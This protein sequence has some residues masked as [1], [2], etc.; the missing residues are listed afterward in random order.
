MARAEKIATVVTPLVAMATLAIGLQIGARSAVRAAI[1]YGAPRAKDS[2]VYA[3]QLVSV[4][5]D[6]GV[7][8]AVPARGITVKAHAKGG[9]AIW[10]GDTNADGVAEIT[11]DM[12]WAKPG[13]AVDL[14]IT[15]AGLD[16]PLGRGAITWSDA[17]EGA[18]ANANDD[19]PAAAFARPSR[20]EGDV[21]LDLA[22][23][24][25]ALTP[26]F[27][28][29]AWIH[30][31]DKA[32][33]ASLAGVSIDAEPE[34]GLS[35]G[36]TKATTCDGGWAEI[37]AEPLIHV[38]GLSLHARARDGRTGDWAGA[39]P[40]A[41]GASHVALPSSIDADSPLSLE[42]VAPSAR[43]IVYLEVDDEAG[44]AYATALALETTP[45]SM[46]RAQFTLPAMHEGLHWLVTSG[47]PRGAESLR[48][49]AIARP[50]WVDA[51]GSRKMD[52]RCTLGPFLATHP[53]SAFPRWIALD[54]FAGRKDANALNQK[55]GLFLA[56]GSIVVAA[57]LEL[58]LILRAVARTRADLARVA[59]SLENDG[60]GVTFSKRTSAGSVVIGVLVALLGFA[61][62][63]SLLM[64]RAT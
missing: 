49:A 55:R 31:T 30:A 28:T 39:P 36:G 38:I 13:D 1:L 6:R 60:A 43:Q 57:L 29:S 27:P 62:L 8:E 46:P 33:G 47:E 42:L 35:L 25:G 26:G 56:M 21:R 19:H 64:W 2:P 40:V 61:L 53:A 9:D 20:R 51:K 15:E 58:L 34:P 17:R 41:P 52:D 24:G 44:R 3:W 10:R 22:I 48:G 45:G 18:H 54:G 4:L 16:A 14:D 32:S 5:D 50:F 37:I 7:R 11:L 63:A 23:V 12:P 59:R